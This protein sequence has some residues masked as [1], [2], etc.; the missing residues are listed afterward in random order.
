MRKNLFILLVLLLFGLSFQTSHAQKKGLYGDNK[1]KPKSST[2]KSPFEQTQ[3]WLG[4]KWGGNFTNVNVG[5]R[6]SVFT[7]VDPSNTELAESFQKEYSDFKKAGWHFGFIVSYNFYKD[8]TATLQPA[9]YRTRYEYVNE[10]NWV[11][12]NNTDQSLQTSYTHTNTID[13]VEFPLTVRY[14]LLQNF[15]VKPYVQVGGFWGIMTRASKQIEVEGIDAAAGNTQ[16]ESTNSTVNINSIYK[17][18]NFGVMFGGGLNADVGN[19]RF[20]LECNYRL[21][22]TQVVDPNKRFSDARLNGIGD[23]LDD[24]KLNSLEFSFGLLFPLKYLT[25]GYERVDP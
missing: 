3:W 18:N 6:Y 21:G 12:S 7:S 2:Q 11:N 4:I 1:K 23:V 24:T 9:F 20:M 16:F 25:G 15:V 8:I 10:Y 22:L 5:D 14:E 13:Y 19:V 17:R